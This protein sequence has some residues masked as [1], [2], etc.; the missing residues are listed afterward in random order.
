MIEIERTNM[1]GHML[2]PIQNG[3]IEMTTSL[4]NVDLYGLVKGDEGVLRNNV[5]SMDICGTVIHA[6]SLRVSSPQS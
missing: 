5:E 4:M 1:V 6:V 2:Y 3:N